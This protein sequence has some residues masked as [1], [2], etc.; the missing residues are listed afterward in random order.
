MII[1]NLQIKTMNKNSHKKYQQSDEI[2]KNLDYRF[3]DKIKIL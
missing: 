2:E 3:N 1:F